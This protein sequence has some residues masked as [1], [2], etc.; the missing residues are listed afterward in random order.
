MRVKTDTRRQA[1][2]EAAR[3]VFN[4]VGYDRASMAQISARVGGSKATLYS[5]F[6]SKEELFAEAMVDAME[7]QAM[8]ML[9]LLDPGEPVVAK[10]LLRFGEAYLDFISSPNAL[11][12]TRLAIGEGGKNEF[13]AKLYS[14]GPKRGW[15]TTS[16]YIAEIMAI[17]ALP[18]ADPHMAAMH[19]RGLLEAGVIMPM[20]FGAEPELER[21]AAVAGAVA[22]FLQVYGMQRENV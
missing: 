5:Y 8:T 16:E 1:I 3:A 21:K 22:V 12:V 18:Q 17:G 9:A 10:V 19:L 2:L 11:R 20:L 7:E 15:S 13:G 6:P 14:L 4:E